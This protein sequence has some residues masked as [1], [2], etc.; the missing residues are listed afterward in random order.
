MQIKSQR[1][2][3]SVAKQEQTKVLKEERKQMDEAIRVITT[4]S[5]KAAK[6]KYLR[7]NFDK[8]FIEK[9]RAKVPMLLENDKSKAVIGDRIAN[10]ADTH[11]NY[12]T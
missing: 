6:E 8:T 3:I 5:S 9:L 11:D 2:L 4:M 12:D 1:E 7:E 10:T